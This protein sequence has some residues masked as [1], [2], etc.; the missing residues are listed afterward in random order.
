M[1][2]RICFV[3]VKYKW[4]KEFVPIVCVNIIY[5][6]VIFNYWVGPS[7]MTVWPSSFFYL[8]ERIFC[9]NWNS[10][11]SIGLRCTILLQGRIFFTNSLIRESIFFH[12]SRGQWSLSMNSIFSFLSEYASSSILK[13][14]PLPKDTAG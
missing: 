6:I 11:Y 9:L 8:I 12:P 1:C 2:R 14:V 10:C 4:F 3:V 7:T 5:R 13:Y